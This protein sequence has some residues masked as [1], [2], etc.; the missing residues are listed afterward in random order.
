LSSSNRDADC[1]SDFDKYESYLIRQDEALFLQNKVNC[2]QTLLDI[3]RIYGPFKQEHIEYYINRLELD[4]DSAFNKFQKECV[5]N[6]FFKFFGSP[7]SAYDINLVGYIK[8]IMAAKKI[9]IAHG[10][11]AFPYVLSSKVVK[12]PFKKAIN[13]SYIS[14]I[15]SD[16][17]WEL[18]K[19]KYR[20][21]NILKDIL[22]KIG[23]AISSE[24]CII[25]PDEPEFDGRTIDYNT[26]LLIAK[27][28][29]EFVL[30]I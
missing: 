6:L 5:F 20:N 29:M 17:L 24:Y 11:V 8:L 26:A 9:L 15:T 22:E 19:D 25:A 23:I 10:M 21:D 30:M 7:R 3:E 13:K 28:Y 2:E 4:G 14:M 16:P 12:M 27:E 18:I 1:Q